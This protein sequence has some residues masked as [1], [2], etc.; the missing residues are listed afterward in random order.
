MYFRYNRRIGSKK[1]EKMPLD[2]KDKEEMSET[3]IEEMKEEAEEAVTVVRKNH[4]LGQ[5]VLVVLIVIASMVGGFF[6]KGIIDSKRNPTIATTD[7]VKNDPNQKPPTDPTKNDPTYTPPTIA[8]GKVVYKI[9]S[10]SITDTQIEKETIK[11]KPPDFE[12]RMKG[13]SEN[14]QKMYRSQLYD[15]ALRNLVNQIYFKLYIT[16]Q[17]MN[18]TQE[19]KDKTKTDLIDMMQKMHEQQNTGTPF[20]LETR[21]KQY[22]ISMEIFLE[23]VT[24][25]TIYRVVTTPILDKIQATEEEAKAFF[26]EHP[27]IFN[28]PAQADLKYILLNSEADADLVMKELTQGSDFT[29]VAKAKSVDP[30]VQSN[31][32]VL[33]WIANDRTKVPGEILDVIFKPGVMIN[34][35]IKIKVQEEWYV[36]IVAG[37]KPEV[38]KQYSEL[39]DKAMYEVKEKKRMEALSAFIKELEAKYGKPVPQQ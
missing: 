27:E 36:M 6:M 12:D 18:I 35:P 11:L 2:E 3:P 37:I 28:E 21:L 20:D 23:D 16:D 29:S 1:G 26:K 14:D 15:N 32:G 4:K 34:M 39:S 8:T 31:G 10:E 13:L 17:K 24:N 22:N 5:V 33:G 7:P 19:D 38:V 25:Q 9:G 30:Q